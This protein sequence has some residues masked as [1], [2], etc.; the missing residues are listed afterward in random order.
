MPKRTIPPTSRIAHNSMKYE[1]IVQ[2]KKILTALRKIRK[3]N[4]QKIA[5]YAGLDCVAVGR[6]LSELTGKGLI[7][8]NGE[9]TMSASG[10]PC[11]VYVLSK[12]AA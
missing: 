2:Q 12:K 9:E 11:A 6:R 7:H 8:P 10:R 5:E 3:G 4:Y 1:K